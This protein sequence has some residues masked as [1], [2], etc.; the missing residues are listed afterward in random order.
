MW[1]SNGVRGAGDRPPTA[2][3]FS[4][5]GLVVGAAPCVWDDLKRA[6]AGDLMVLNRMAVLVEQPVRHLASLHHDHIASLW[7]FRRALWRHGDGHVHTHSPKAAAGVESVWQLEGGCSFSGL[8]GAAVMLALGYA[9][10]ILCGCPHDAEG[11]VW[12]PGATAIHHSR[13]V[14]IELE[15]WRDNA[16]RG[17][18]QSMSGKTRAILG[19]PDGL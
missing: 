17:R 8:F 7:A 10:V 5:V 13:G 16:F 1:E 15:W 2:G 14:Q 18:V 3:N 19:A 12:Q 6:P 9:P 11:Y 4:G